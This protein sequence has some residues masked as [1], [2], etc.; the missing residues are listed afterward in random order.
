MGTGKHLW[1][2]GTRTVLPQL[3]KR[4]VCPAVWASDWTNLREASIPITRPGRK[5]RH[6]QFGESSW[7]S[8]HLDKWQEAGVFLVPRHG[9]VLAVVPLNG[10]KMVVFM[11][12]LLFISCI[13]LLFLPTDSVPKFPSSLLY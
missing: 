9:L 4:A 2:T 5:W 3:K 7:L 13:F 11:L 8:A 10:V 1:A 6:R 12:L